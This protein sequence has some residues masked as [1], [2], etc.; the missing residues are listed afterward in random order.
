MIALVPKSETTKIMV[1]QAA[2]QLHSISSMVETLRA[3][4]NRTAS[5][6]PEYP[7]VMRMY[8]VGESIG[9]Q[10]MA[11]IGDIRRFA[12]KKLLTV[13]LTPLSPK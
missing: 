10:L 11:E 8:G 5:L 7:A 2:Q 9:P 3:E 13:H 4:M 6:L 1:Q 12:G